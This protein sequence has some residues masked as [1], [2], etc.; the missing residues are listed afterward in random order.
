MET[1]AFKKLNEKRLHDNLPPFAN[2]RNAAAGSLRQLDARMTARRPL[3][4]F[5]YGIGRMDGGTFE[6]QYDLMLQL[7]QW[8]L[9]VNRPHI[10]ICD[11][12][13]DVIAY[14][15]HLEETRA[16]FFYEIDGT[17]IKVNRID[18]QERL[19][20]KSRT[21]RWSIAYKFKPTRETAKVIKIDVQVGRTGALTPVAHLKPVEIGGVWVKRATLHNTEEIEKKD[22]RA[23]DTVVVQRAGDVIPEI[24]KSV[25]SKRTGHEQP[26]VMPTQCPV[27][28]TGVVKKPGE[29]VMRCP[30]IHCPAQIRESL[31]H[32]TS[33]GAVNIDGLGDKLIAQLMAR[34]MVHDE[35]DLYT[36]TFDDLL[37]L[38]K[39]KEKAAGNIIN[40][41]EKSKRTTLTKFIY[42]LGIRHVGEYGASLL[43]D[44]FGD[45]AALEKATEAELLAIDGIGPQIAESVVTF[46]ADERNRQVIKRLLDSGI[47]FESSAAGASQVSGKHFVLTGALPD[48]RRSEAKEL[49]ARHGGRIGSSVSART[50]YLVAGDAPGSKL[51]KARELG[52]V[53]LNQDQFFALLKDENHG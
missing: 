19:G 11:T 38:D 35:A 20:K 41:L 17:V 29:A 48:L 40:A 21:P 14:C 13:E 27:C 28:G 37:E 24:V 25:K 5:C 31:K 4:I 12:P 22:I 44:Y 46:F 34:G 53:I 1:E 50:D 43:A 47:M 18:L 7:Q 39:I 36:L 30:N 10:R 3:D 33:K 52:V 2:P 51:K 6:T 32:F 49:I 42:A 8:G 23:G 45:M 26:F 16:D 15:H 9:R